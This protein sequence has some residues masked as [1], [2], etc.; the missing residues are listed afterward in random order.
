MSAYVEV[1]A[2]FTQL[3]GDSVLVHEGVEHP[4]PE[5]VPLSRGGSSR[6]AA[7]RLLVALR[8]LGLEPDGQLRD[9]T[10]ELTKRG[11]RLRVRE[12]AK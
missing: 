2:E 7:H 12:V 10:E 8:D 6:M 5:F 4:I 3:R 9:C 11:F 1:T